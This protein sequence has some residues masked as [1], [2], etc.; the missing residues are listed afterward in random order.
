MDNIVE[1]L[2][3]AHNFEKLCF[4]DK[5]IE[6]NTLT[7]HFLNKIKLNNLP[8]QA[9]VMCDDKTLQC[10]NKRKELLKIKNSLVLKKYILIKDDN[11]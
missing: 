3:L 11:V 1:A 2:Y 6:C 5:A 9:I 10:F 4:I 8:I 7:M